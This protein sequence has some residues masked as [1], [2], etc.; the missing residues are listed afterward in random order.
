MNCELSA[1]RLRELLHYNPETGDLTWI[2]D[3]T[4][5]V[6]A[7]DRAGTR[8]SKKYLQIRVG[9]RFYQAHRL[10]WL[11]MTGEWPAHHI[12]HINCI[13]DDNRWCNLRPAS[14]TQNLANTKRYLNNTSGF[15]GVSFHR[16]SQKWLAQIRANNV[17]H[18][19]GIYKTP[20]EAHAAYCSAATKLFGEFARTV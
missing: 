12:D 8:N 18:Y 4:N 3:L 7:G 1:E 19:L 16:P 15:K 9:K 13:R 6:R 17:F 11:Y 10:A 14:R 2:T 20:E 5:N